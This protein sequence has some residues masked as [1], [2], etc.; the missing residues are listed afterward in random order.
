MI[1]KSNKVRGFKK[2]YLYSSVNII[3]I[4]LPKI[5]KIYAKNGLPTHIYNEME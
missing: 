4:L 2:F 3:N 1:R 5:N